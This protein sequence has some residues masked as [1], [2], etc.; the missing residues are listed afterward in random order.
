MTPDKIRQ[1][2]VIDPVDVSEEEINQFLESK[3]W[4][5]M[6]QEVAHTLAFAYDVLRSTQADAKLIREAQGVVRGLEYF[7]G[8]PDA[9]RAIAASDTFK[10]E[11]VFSR[12]DDDSESIRMLRVILGY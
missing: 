1:V 2:T 7:L 6:R 11:Q 9:I 3:M 5:R 10:N 12:H 8:K 4:L